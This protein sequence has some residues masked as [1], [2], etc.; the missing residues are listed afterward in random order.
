LPETFPAYNSSQDQI[1]NNRGRRKYFLRPFFEFRIMLQIPLQIIT[2]DQNGFHLMVRAAIGRL[3]VN[4]LIDTGASR[5]VFDSNRISQYFGK[6]SLEQYPKS[7][8]GVGVE[9]L[10]T[11]SLVIP[12]LQFGNFSMKQTEVMVID[13]GTVN[14]SYA[15]LD[16]PRIDMVMGGDLLV[17]YGGIIDYPQ[18]QLVFTRA[19]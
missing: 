1:I 10:H 6:V 11:Q 12:E 2:I 5:T 7:F 14:K 16:L 4:L 8:T 18:Q 9:N 15:A 13:L 19:L 3:P 17:R